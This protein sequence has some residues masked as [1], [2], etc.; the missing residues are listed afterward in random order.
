MKFKKQ[1]EAR[2]DYDNLGDT[3]FVETERSHNNHLVQGNNQKL[4]RIDID[5]RSHYLY[6]V[7]KHPESANKVSETDKKAIN[8]VIQ[9]LKS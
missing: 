5:L 9:K 3:C 7:M 6:E 4:Q 8:I 1:E 2:R